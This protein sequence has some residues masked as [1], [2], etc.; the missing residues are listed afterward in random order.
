MKDVRR[1]K[2]WDASIVLEVQDKIDRKKQPNKKK[3]HARNSLLFHGMA[4]TS[5]SPRDLCLV[6]IHI[7]WRERRNVQ[8]SPSHTA[9][10]LN[11]VPSEREVAVGRG[12]SSGLT[13]T[14]SEQSRCE[15]SSEAVHTCQAAACEADSRGWRVQ[16][17][18][19]WQCESEIIC[20]GSVAGNSVNAEGTSLESFLA[21]LF[22]CVHFFYKSNSLADTALI[23]LI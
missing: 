17:R 16:L 19:P 20:C 2:D 7:P 11:L 13:S 12:G 10:Q 14:A 6:K 23:D 4:H 21:N 18:R 8:Q 9:G 15:C 1:A 3:K 22:K 5:K